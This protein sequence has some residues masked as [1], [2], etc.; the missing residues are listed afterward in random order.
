MNTLDAAL[1]DMFLQSQEELRAARR[2]ARA[3]KAC[4]KRMHRKLLRAESKLKRE[5]QRPHDW[6]RQ[7]DAKP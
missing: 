3:W 4:A 2:A 5:Y 6:V 7:D 1:S